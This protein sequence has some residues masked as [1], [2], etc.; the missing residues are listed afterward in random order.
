MELSWFTPSWE[1]NPCLLSIQGK[2]SLLY[3]CISFLRF[4]FKNIEITKE[5]TFLGL[6][7]EF[8]WGLRMVQTL[9]AW[10]ADGTGE[11]LTFSQFGIFVFLVKPGG[12]KGTQHLAWRSSLHDITRLVLWTL[13]LLILPVVWV[14]IPMWVNKI[15]P[16]SFYWLIVW[17][18]GSQSDPGR[19]KGAQL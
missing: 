4:H 16:V 19:S 5:L 9:M 6:V 1:S 15:N 17:R 12:A 2:I 13:M 8:K 3:C 7:G 10:N 11:Q 18:R 14:A